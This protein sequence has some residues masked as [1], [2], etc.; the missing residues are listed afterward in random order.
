MTEKR[1]K[2]KLPTGVEFEGSEVGVTEVT[3]RWS[4]IL[5]EDGSRL[6]V[7]PNVLGALRADGQYDPEGNPVYALKSS[8]IM[9]VV[10]API[11]LRKGATSGKAN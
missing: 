8:Q 2:V 3:E 11:H 7:K 5:L 6:K 1:V 10:S 4:E 9:M